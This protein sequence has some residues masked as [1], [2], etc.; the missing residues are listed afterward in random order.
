CHK[1]PVRVFS[2]ADD[3]AG[4]YAT[5]EVA[6]DAPPEAIAAAYRRK[7]RVLHPDVPGTGD[8]ASFIRVKQAYDVLSDPRRRAAY[9]RPAVPP[10]LPP[11]APEPQPRGPRLSDLP[12]PLWAG[13]GGLLCIAA[14]MA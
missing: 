11:V 14:V 4:Y 12:M 2:M 10:P 1:A 8:A 13:L 3:S 6:P 5:L 7:A 9:D